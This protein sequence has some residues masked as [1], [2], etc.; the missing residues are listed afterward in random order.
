[1]D[2]GLLRRGKLIEGHGNDAVFD[3]AVLCQGAEE[4]FAQIKATA[5]GCL[6]DFDAKIAAIEGREGRGHI[7]GM[8]EKPPIS[9]GHRVGRDR[10]HGIRRELARLTQETREGRGYGEI[11]PVSVSGCDQVAR[12][13]GE[14]D[15]RGDR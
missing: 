15:G 6:E 14:I 7:A 13:C 3:D 4:N 11:P 5:L 10:Q 9:L 1:M 12:P 8:H 2:D